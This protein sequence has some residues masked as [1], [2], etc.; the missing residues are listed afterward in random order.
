M[1]D[2]VVRR[3][4]ADRPDKFNEWA[5]LTKRVNKKYSRRKPEPLH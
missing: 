3:A 2:A 4:L 5:K 1:T